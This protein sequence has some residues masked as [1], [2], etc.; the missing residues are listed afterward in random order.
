VEE[1]GIYR[2]LAEIVR[3]YGNGEADEL[4]LEEIGGGLVDRAGKY[5]DWAYG[6]SK[7]PQILAETCGG[8]QMAK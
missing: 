2:S 8:S 3:Y 4:G 7:Y 6:A 5:V 1:H